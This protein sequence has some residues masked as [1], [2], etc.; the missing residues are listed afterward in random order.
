MLAPDITTRMAAKHRGEYGAKHPSFVPFCFVKTVKL[1]WRTNHKPRSSQRVR[2]PLALSLLALSARPGPAAETFVPQNRTVSLNYVYAA[3]LGF[4]GYS[5][6]GL[7]ANV[8]T[9]PYV[10]TVPLD[11]AP[12]MSL[13]IRLPLQAG[14]YQLRVTD[15]DGS[16]LSLNQ[17]SLAFVPRAELQVPVARNFLL[18]P[19]AEAGA[20]HAFGTTDNPNAWI[21]SFGIR[22]VAATEL[23]PYRLTLGNAVI[24][25][26]DRTIGSGP[27][28]S[29]VSIA[30]GLE[31]RRPF[32]FTIRGYQPDFGIYVAHYY[33]P[34]P[35]TFTQFL[36]PNLKVL[37]Q[38]EVGF[39]VGSVPPLDVLG[40][41][42][43]RIGAGYVFG[44]GLQ[45]YRINFGFP[46]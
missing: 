6:S 25:A 29:Y 2:I 39:S 15:I 31:I 45:V 36:R 22:S 12:G 35:L 3:S 40:F 21:Y 14:L 34:K 20:G 46:F 23:G 4:G 10:F 42:D 1:R 28:E 37:N 32:D 7:T 26:G 8:F 16:R 5:L 24:Y 30:T 43:A 19:F 17:Q 44:G 11:E 27:G 38:G 13:R 41:K 33:Y 9:L 18:K